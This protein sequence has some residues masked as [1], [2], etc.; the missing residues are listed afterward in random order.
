MN[1]QTTLTSKITA[2]FPKLNLKKINYLNSGIDNDIIFVNDSLVF[3]FPKKADTKRL[4]KT[5]LP[6]LL[7]LNKHLKTK[8]PNPQYVAKD[9]S[10]VGYPL[11]QGTG[12]TVPMFKA[13]TASQQNK[14]AKDLAN[15]LSE[16]HAISPS[17]LK[18][19][20]LRTRH[21]ATELRRLK[22]AYKTYLAPK[23]SIK[24]KQIFA[25]FFTN[26]AIILKYPTKPV[27]VHGDLS[28][29][30]LVVT[31]RG[32]LAG[33]IDFTDRAIHE[34]AFDFV[35]LWAFGPEFVKS[36]AAHYY[37]PSQNLVDRSRLFAQANAVWNMVYAVKI[38]HS[39]TSFNREYRTFKKLANH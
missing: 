13:L 7:F 19:F 12:L 36:V 5:E 37:Q 31:T 28:G 20:A 38:S 17:Q 39:Q 2:N 15:F 8:L 1:Q 3:R 4:L 21:A 35:H 14:L 26:L 34:A 22:L 11:I 16:L 27:L 25:D 9:T 30:N 18:P 6:F 32:Q 29:D 10:F 24:D 33:V 23:I